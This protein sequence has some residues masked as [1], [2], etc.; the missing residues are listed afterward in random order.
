[1]NRKSAR[2]TVLAEKCIVLMLRA[3][4]AINI[5]APVTMMFPRKITAPAMCNNVCHL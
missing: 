1:M 2:M 5:H 3:R 4:S